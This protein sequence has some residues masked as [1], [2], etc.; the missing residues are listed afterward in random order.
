MVYSDDFSMYPQQGISP[1][2]DMYSNYNSYQ[3]SGMANV[4]RQQQQQRRNNST[5]HYHGQ[6]PA[7]KSWPAFGME[8]GKIGDWNEKNWSYE[9]S[10]SAPSCT[11]FSANNVNSNY[12]A[13]YTN[14]PT[15]SNI[16][17]QQPY[18]YYNNFSS[19]PSMSPESFGNVSPVHEQ[20]QC[21]R[22]GLSK[23]P[24]DWLRKHDYSSLPASGKTRTKDKYRVV[25]TDHQRLELEKEFCYSKYITIKRKAELAN[26]L[27]LSERQVKIWF[28]NRRAKERKQKKKQ[29]TQSSDD[30]Q[31]STSPFDT[32]IMTGATIEH[33]PSCMPLLENIPP[34]MTT[35]APSTTNHSPNQSPSFSVSSFTSDSHAY[36]AVSPAN[37][38][39]TSESNNVLVNVKMESHHSPRGLPFSTDSMQNTHFAFQPITMEHYS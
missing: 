31:T 8:S 33:K 11:H 34:M 2:D 9:T 16:V 17:T 15:N 25:Y 10:V 23:A 29:T 3:A 27:V 7:Q 12:V 20:E 13:A 4:C 5:Y 37:Q 26:N 35:S 30:R 38:L 24:F 39:Y 36:Q 18:D 32:T 19:S 14:M 28:Q 6:L 1:I 22:Q 21:Q